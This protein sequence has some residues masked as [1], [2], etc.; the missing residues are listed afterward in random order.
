MM[1]IRGSGLNTSIWVLDSGCAGDPIDGQRSCGSG[2]SDA[3]I[4]G[5]I[6]IEQNIS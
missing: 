6:D 1:H 5:G 2:C 4:S 3:D